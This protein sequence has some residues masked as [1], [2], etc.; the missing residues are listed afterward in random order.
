MDPRGVQQH[1]VLSRYATVSEFAQAILSDIDSIP[2]YNGGDVFVRVESLVSIERLTGFL[3]SLKNIQLPPS[4][5]SLKPLRNFLE[6]RWESIRKTDAIYSHQPNSQ[7]NRLCLLLA[8]KL[9]VYHEKHPYELLI[10]TAV[11]FMDYFPHH[12]SDT[13]KLT[14]FIM[15]DTDKPL[16]VMDAFALIEREM[17]PANH[18]D[19][20]APAHVTGKLTLNEDRLL[21]KH[22][23]AAENYYRILKNRGS[24]PREIEAAKCQLSKFMAEIPASYEPQSTYALTGKRKLAKLM[25]EYVGDRKKLVAL[26]AHMIPLVEWRVFQAAITDDDY[27]RYMGMRG[28]EIQRASVIETDS[29]YNTRRFRQIEQSLKTLLTPP[30]CLALTELNDILLVVEDVEHKKSALRAYCYCLLQLYRRVRSIQP[31]TTSIMGRYTSSFF[32]LT[33]YGCSKEEKI[34][35]CD[36]IEKMLIEN[37]SLVQLSSALESDKMRQYQKAIQEGH[38]GHLLSIIKN[39]IDRACTLEDPSRR[40]DWVRTVA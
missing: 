17:M 11:G 19:L 8:Q 37:H 7:I 36:A 34:N 22:S 9:A 21:S 38:L 23:S 35:A 25:L 18:S 31:E 20:A 16:L 28:F 40:R 6:Q 3:T 2:A 26:F 27:F 39:V 15:R 24:Q 13:I 4:S 10:P 30:P 29:E 32:Q 12:T 33:S 5:E 14:E 1:N